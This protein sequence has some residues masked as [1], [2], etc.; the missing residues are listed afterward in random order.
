[1]YFRD[2][3]RGASSSIEEDICDNVV[4]V[5]SESLLLGLCLLVM[6]FENCRIVC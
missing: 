6:N 1:M 4:G 3:E 2:I 5:D